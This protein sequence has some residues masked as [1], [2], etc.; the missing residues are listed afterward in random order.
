MEESKEVLD[1]QREAHHQR[2]DVVQFVIL[3]HDPN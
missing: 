1:V 2:V 3:K